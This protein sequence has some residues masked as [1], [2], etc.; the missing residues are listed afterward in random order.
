M[1]DALDLGSSVE[2]RKSS[3]LFIRIKKSCYVNYEV[4]IEFDLNV[5]VFC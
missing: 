5:L 3:S 2:I 4:E 1:V